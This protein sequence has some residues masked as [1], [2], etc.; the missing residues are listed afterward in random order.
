MSYLTRPYTENRYLL[1][2]QYSARLC[3]PCC[4]LLQFF[5]DSMARAVIA[6]QTSVLIARAKMTYELT[7]RRN[8]SIANAID[9]YWESW[10]CVRTLIVPILNQL[11]KLP[12]FVKIF[13]WCNILLNMFWESCM[14]NLITLFCLLNSQIFFAML[15]CVPG[16][17]IKQ[18]DCWVSEGWLTDSCK[19]WALPNDCE[20]RESFSKNF[21]FK[22]LTF[23]QVV[24]MFKF[25]L[26]AVETSF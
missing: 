3:A 18:S 16:W 24:F 5:W 19:N 4:G 25:K 2:P 23:P 14:Q 17:W 13:I 20:R 21:K 10:H 6:C 11:C 7:L 1:S 22:Y 26:R 12:N 9:P 8:G 15:K